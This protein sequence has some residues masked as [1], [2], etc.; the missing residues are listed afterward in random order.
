MSLERQVGD[1]MLAWACDEAA[2]RPVRCCDATAG[3][4]DSGG[5]ASVLKA[6]AL[7]RVAVAVG[8]HRKASAP[9]WPPAWTRLTSSYHVGAPGRICSLEL[10]SLGLAP[11]TQLAQRARPLSLATVYAL[12]AWPPGAANASPCTCT[13]HS[14]R[15]PLQLRCGPAAK[16]AGRGRRPLES[17]HPGSRPRQGQHSW[18]PPPGQSAHP[19]RRCSSL[20]CSMQAGCRAARLQALGQSKF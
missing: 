11:I 5:G 16:G 3:A 12:P 13:R 19:A 9:G 14:C 2:L 7:C 4:S 18:P 20:H 1:D 8:G 15:G 6:R 10:H 17:S